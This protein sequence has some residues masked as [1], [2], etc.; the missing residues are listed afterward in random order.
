MPAHVKAALP[1]NNL[2]IP[3]VAGRLG[4]SAWQGVYLWDRR[5]RGSAR[6]I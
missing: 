6:S 3:V 4:L 1:A 2:A 5:H